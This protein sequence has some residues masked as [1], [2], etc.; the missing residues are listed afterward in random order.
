MMRQGAEF[1]GAMVAGFGAAGLA[2][3]LDLVPESWGP[4]GPL[5]QGAA[6]RDPGQKLSPVFRTPDPE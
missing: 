3:I 1:G 5:C 4:A 2:Q 6:L